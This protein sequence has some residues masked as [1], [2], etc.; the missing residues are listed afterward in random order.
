M[1]KLPAGDLMGLSLLELLRR[2]KASGL[3]AGD[4]EQP[5]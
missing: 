3:F 5:H 4:P 1:M 2:R